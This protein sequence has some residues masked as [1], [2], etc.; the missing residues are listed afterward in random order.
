MGISLALYQ[1]DHTNIV[2]KG[3]ALVN[4]AL[5]TQKTENLR[6]FLKSLRFDE[7]PELVEYFQN[8]VDRLREVEAPP[9]II[10]WEEKRL[11]SVLPPQPGFI[12]WLSLDELRA[13]LGSWCREARSIDLDK[14]W[15]L[16]HWYCDPNRRKR[17]DGGWRFLKYYTPSAFDY[18]FHGE[19]PY[20]LDLCGDTVIRTGGLQEMSWYNSP[21]VV[22][23]IAQ[24]MSRTDCNDWDVIDEQMDSL[25][26]EKRPYLSGIQ[27][28]LNSVM[29]T[30]SRLSA[31]YISAAY[32]GFG[33]SVEFY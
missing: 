17:L 18:A 23:Q 5:R 1:V 32:R 26:E 6:T 16:I 22:D 15:D 10:E 11:A 20:P 31:F 3:L 33:V 25:S 9:M 8:R 14:L 7:S 12:D 28:R 19:A 2:V 13:M 29:K 24:A 4:E 30:F 21:Q 27:D